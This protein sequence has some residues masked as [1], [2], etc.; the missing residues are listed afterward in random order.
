M[1]DAFK[2][3]LSKACAKL[4]RPLVRV[5]LRHGI[6][7]WEFAEVAKA[8]YVDVARRDFSLPARKSSD[9]RVAILTGL[10]RKDVKR[11]RELL[12]GTAPEEP[13]SANRA[14][15]VLSAWHQDSEFCGADGRPVS[16]PLQGRRRSFVALVRRYSGDMPARAILEEL[17]R[18]RAVRRASDGRVRVLTRSYLPGD[19]DPQGVRIL[20]TAVGDLLA[21]IDHNLDRNRKGPR[22]LQRSVSKLRLDPRSVPLFRRIASERGQSLLET[23]DDWLSAHQAEEGQGVRV[24]VGIYLFQDEP[25]PEDET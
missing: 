11:L 13:L 5:L 3:Q 20:G 15:R 16:L 21:T 18:V 7:F 8:V 14:T 6:A 10:T 12:E 1:R 23:L 22:R 4:L 9:S 19:D 25:V 24:G 2:T 17:E